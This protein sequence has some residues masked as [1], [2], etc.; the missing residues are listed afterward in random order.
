MSRVFIIAEAGVNHNGS[1]EIAKKLIDAAVDS[2]AD[3]V[4]FQTFCAKN[5]VTKSAATARYQHSNTKSCSQHELLEKLELTLEEHQILFNYCNKAEIQFLSTAFDHESID[6]IT[7][8]GVDTFKIPSGEITNVPYMRKIGQLAGKVILSTGM[9]TLDD[10]DYALKVLIQSGTSKKN[11]TVL[12]ANTAYPTPMSDVNLRAMETISKTFDVDVGY[13]DHSLGIE[14][15]IAAVALGARVIEKHLTL[16]K[17]MAGPDHKASIEPQEFKAMVQSIRNIE[18]ALGSGKKEP[19]QSELENIDLV[20]KSIVAR[21]DIKL[22]EVL[23][24]ENMIVKRP[25][26]GLSPKNWDDL[27]GTQAKK[28]YSEDEFI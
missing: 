23:T 7:S 14:V 8:L 17:G 2:G 27:V 4:K 26:L 15:D 9:A 6:L 12:H 20:R 28:N 1:L 3:A 22:G 21:C 16:D 24:E 19:S 10:I 25:G 18:T 11:I 5:L 13:S